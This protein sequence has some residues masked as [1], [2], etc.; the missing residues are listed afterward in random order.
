MASQEKQVGSVAQSEP[1]AFGEDVR[2]ALQGGDGDIQAVEAPEAAIE[3][4][5]I[6]LPLQPF[7]IPWLL[8]ASG[9]YEW[10]FPIFQIP[11]PI[12]IP[13]PIPFPEP[14][15]L[16]PGSEAGAQDVDAAQALTPLPFWFQREEL[17]LDVDGQHPQMVVSGTLFSGLTTRVHWIANLTPSRLSS[18]TYTGFIW[19]KDG[20]GAALPQTNVTVQVTKS[21]FSSQRKVTVT[22]TGGG[23]PN[24]VR[25]YAWKSSYFHPAEFEYD[26]VEGTTALTSIN[27]GDHPNRPAGLPIENL[28]IETAYRR[29]GFAVTKSGGDAPIPILEAGADALWSDMEMHDAMQAYWSR[30]ANAPQWSMWVLFAWQHVAVPSRGITPDNLGGIMFDD[31]GPNHRQGTA[32]FNGSFIKDAPAGDPSPAAWVRRIKFWTACH[33]M[34]H[35]FNLAHSWR[36]SFGTPWIPLTNE[37]EARSFMN[38]PYNVSGGES[39]FFAD[40]EYRFSDAE[41]LFLRHAPHR[42]LQPGNADWFDDHGFRQADVA[43]RPSFA[44]ELRVHRDVDYFEFLEPVTIEAKLTNTANQPQ[45]IPALILEDQGEMTVI[46]KKDGKRARQWS[47]FAHYRDSGDKKVLHPGESIYSSLFLGAGVNGWDLAE[48]GVYHVQAAL[49]M[50]DEDVVSNALRVRVAPP[51]SYEEEFL[52]QDFFSEDVGRTLAFGGTRYLEGANDTLRNVAEQL[53]DR[54]VAKHAHLALGNPLTRD[55]KRLV[56]EREANAAAKAIKVEEAKPEEAAKQLAQALMQDP[57]EA[58]GTLGHIA[59]KAQVD[60]YAAFL[61]DH[62]EADEAAAR[63]QKAEKTL[64]ARGVLPSVLKDMKQQRATYAKKSSGKKNAKK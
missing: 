62:G 16:D 63:L 30:F 9:L 17:R 35:A 11:Q 6:P 48:P 52:A 54:R 10:K 4:Q 33:E 25:T 50:E 57:D 29:A 45:V 22:F 8:R 21:W 15:P 43:A 24:Q 49:H 5:P 13:R 18:N 19:Y 51:R 2:L 32:I 36:K 37:P 47:P 20:N 34:G 27:T 46:I 40:F 61:A 56:V 60:Q 59:Y 53:E 31:I 23:A 7:P 42:F 41:L 55:Y 38:Y 39:A 28:S 26:A 44:L 1:S 3:P 14:G 58:A 64:A 12:P